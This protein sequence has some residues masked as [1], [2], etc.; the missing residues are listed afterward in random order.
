MQGP[1]APFA[2]GSPLSNGESVTSASHGATNAGVF[3]LAARHLTVDSKVLDLGAGKGYM[4]RRL[5]KW[6]AMQGRDPARNVIACDVDGTAYAVTEIPFQQFDADAGLPFGDESFDLIVAIEVFEH[7]SNV[8]H[9]FDECRRVL[10]HGGLLVISVPNIG[11]TISRLKFLLTGF[12][13]LYM[14]PSTDPKNAGR[15]CGHIMPLTF[16]YLSYGLRRAGFHGI[17][18]H[19]DKTKKAAAI[20]TPLF[21]P[22]IRCSSWFYRRRVR[23]Y[24]TSVFAENASVIRQMSSWRML[25]ARSCIIA[26]IK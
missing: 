8:Y 19:S 22:L 15:L 7:M 24:D 20:L 10:K 6:F 16:A 26:A 4:T 14:P 21:Y 13:D 17:V 9:Q 25:T 12:Y 2:A 23:R 11:H 1:S 18:F 3:A 5:G